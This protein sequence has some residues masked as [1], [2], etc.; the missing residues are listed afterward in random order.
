MVGPREPSRITCHSSDN[1]MRW[2]AD[3]TAPGLPERFQHDSTC[4][5]P[6]TSLTFPDVVHMA[7]PFHAQVLWPRVGYSH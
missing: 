3:R 1:Q 7:E 6:I 5:T 2:E 4:Q